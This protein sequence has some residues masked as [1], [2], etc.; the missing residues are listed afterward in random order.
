MIKSLFFINFFL[1]ITSLYK[2]RLNYLQR[3]FYLMTTKIWYIFLIIFFQMF[4]GI[5]AS[6]NW[7]EQLKQYLQ[8]PAPC[9]MERQIKE[10]FEKCKGVS[11][12]KRDVRGAYN[13]SKRNAYLAY[14]RLRGSKVF[15]DLKFVT[16]SHQFRRNGLVKAFKDLGQVVLLPRVELLYAIGDLPEMEA[17]KIK[18]PILVASASKNHQNAFIFFPDGICLSRYDSFMEEVQKANALYPW[19]QKINR[20]IWRGGMTGTI[21]TNPMPG[22]PWK[23][24]DFFKY[25]RTR[26]MELAQDNPYLIDA[27]Y[28]NSTLIYEYLALK[29]PHFIGE[30]ISIEEHIKF[31]YQLLIDG[32]SAAW[33]RALWQFFSNCFILKQESNFMQWYYNGLQPYVHYL[34]VK[35]DLSDLVEN[36]EKLQKNEKDYLQI[37]EN[38]QAFAQERLSYARMLQYIYLV[39]LEYKKHVL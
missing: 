18:A 30:K 17:L 13:N 9:W 8:E 11:F 38:A 3:F 4:R 23:E 12:K 25:P 22:N 21:A 24:K 2:K 16:P 33:D 5:C 1:Q 14:F 27:K 39:L 20:L 34:P 26:L 29:Y 6:E 37:I 35:K 15:S 32:N 31:K 19:D 10:D 7:K 36:L 28:A